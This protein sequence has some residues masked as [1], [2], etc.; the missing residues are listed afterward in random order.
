MLDKAFSKII[1]RLSYQLKR[2]DGTVILED[3]G[4][5]LVV[6]QADDVTAKLVGG[7]PAGDGLN[8]TYVKYVAVGTDGT[9]VSPADTAIT[10]YEMY[11][12]TSVTFPT[13]GT[14]EFNFY[15]DFANA[16]N[17]GGAALPI[18][19]FGLYTS[20]ATA[21]SRKLYARIVKPAIAKDVNMSITGKWTVTY[22]R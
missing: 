12:F 1:G 9:A 2:P 16:N 13:P 7:G 19:E 17:L 22:V 11:P 8:M 10:N 6:S 18:Q 21:S 5:N 4:N 15:I 20:E 3:E 14:I